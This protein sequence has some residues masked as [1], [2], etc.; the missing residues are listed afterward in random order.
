MVFFGD[1]IPYDDHAQRAVRMALEMRATMA[2]LQQQW[3]EDRGEALTIGIG[4][5]TG[6]VT[7]GN[8][9]SPARLD[10]TVLGNHVNLASRLAGRAVAGQI[11]ISDRT[12]AAVRELVVAR[13]IDQVELKGVSRPIK[14]YDVEEA[15]AG[16]PALG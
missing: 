4:I 12:Y 13:E 15:R 7:V 1:P 11:L 3:L 16:A 9:G 14:I 5:S 8:I 10:Y 2:T 6:Y